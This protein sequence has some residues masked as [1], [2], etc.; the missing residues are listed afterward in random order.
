MLYNSFLASVVNIL[1]FAIPYI[2]T[3]GEEMVTLICLFEC[4]L[5]RSYGR[6]VRSRSGV[7]TERARD[8]SRPECGHIGSL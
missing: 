3:A 4:Y 8:M 2:Y 7:C 5:Y 6:Y 1:P